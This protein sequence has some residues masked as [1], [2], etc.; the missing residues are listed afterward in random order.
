MK[1][2]L[3]LAAVLV[4]LAG[5]ATAQP[6][7]TTPST[8]QPSRNGDVTA[9]PASPGTGNGQS[10]VPRGSSQPGPAQETIPQQ[11]SGG[12]GA[13]LWPATGVVL[14]V[15]GGLLIFYSMRRQ[16]LDP[17]TQQA[18]DDATREVFKQEGEGPT[19]RPGR[20]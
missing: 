13:I 17:R 1:R 16:R 14:L 4:P 19:G 12:A 15:L 9:P 18:H 11:S 5:A 8:S 7:D 2:L 10:D 6:T 3:L 20:P